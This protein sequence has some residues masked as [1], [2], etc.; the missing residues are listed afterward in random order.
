MSKML[1][2]EYFPWLRRR[3]RGWRLLRA[4]NTDKA[5][6][7]KAGEQHKKQNPHTPEQEASGNIWPSD[8]R[9][10]STQV[11]TPINWYWLPGAL[12]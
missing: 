2:Q 5:S 1:S 10:S 12:P 9:W 7:G 8:G 4:G 3:L 6:L 11:P